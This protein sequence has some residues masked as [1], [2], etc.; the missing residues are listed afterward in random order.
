MGGLSATR[1]PNAA[2]SDP[3]VTPI[4]LDDLPD[5]EKAK[6]LERHLVPKG[7]RGKMTPQGADS[8]S[9][10]ASLLEVP[11]GSESGRTLSRRSSQG[12]V[13]REDSE[14]FP[15]LYDAHGADVT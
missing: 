14:P 13:R 15:I 5:E 7:Q 10:S 8:K 6:V 9:S 1:Q 11:S 12:I 3:S 2:T 4:D